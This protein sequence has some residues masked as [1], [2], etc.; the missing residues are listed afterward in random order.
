M[1]TNGT[2]NG[3]KYGNGGI[4]LILD[5]SRTAISTPRNESTLAWTLSF[6]VSGAINWTPNAYPWSVTIDGQKFSGTWT[7]SRVSSPGKYKIA[8]G[9]VVVEHTDDGSKTFNASASFVANIT[10]SGQWVTNMALS[11]SGT[12]DTIDR[13]TVPTVSTALAKTGTTVTINLPRKSSSF[14]HRVTWKIGTSAGTIATDAGTSCD[15]TIP[16]AIA[17]QMPNQIKRACTITAVTLLNGAEIGA[18]DTTFNIQVNDQDVPQISAVSVSEA[19]AGI[20]SKFEAF[21]QGQSKLK[22]EI[23]ASGVYSS[24]IESYETK[25]LNLSFDKSEFTT[26]TLTTGGQLTAEIK[27]TDSRGRS[28]T[29]TQT[30]EVL[31]YAPPTIEAFT[32]ER[33]N[34]AGEVDDEGTHLLATMAF[35][36]TSLNELNDKAYKLEYKKQTVETWTELTSGAVYSFNDD[37]LSG[38]ILEP[39][40]SYNLRLTIT[41]YFSET[42]APFDISTTPSLLNLSNGGTGLGIGKSAEA[43]NLMDVGIEAKFRKPVSFSQDTD[44][45]PVPLTDSFQAYQGNTANAPEYRIRNKVVEVRGI[46]SPKTSYTS[47]FSPVAFATMPEGVRPDKTIYELCSGSNKDTWTLTLTSAG[48]LGVSQLGGSSYGTVSTNARLAFHLI[49]TLD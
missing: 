10:Y 19:V 40:S 6:Y 47:A 34:S 22:F 31:E 38:D 21:I 3:T 37:F 27:V 2:I 48:A 24:T 28:T 4:W 32:V 35:N 13:P 30:I 1:A 25:F 18:V 17:N 7:R 42:S 11:G 45:T 44:W 15:W 33:A 5:W 26:N 41:D 39:D 46:V 23:T 20:A 8:S 43:E 9:S 29:T 12:L 49:F 36:I 16:R 14:T